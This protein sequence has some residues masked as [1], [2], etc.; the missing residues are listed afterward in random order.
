MKQPSLSAA[1][2]ISQKQRHSALQA[3]MNILQKWG[4]STEEMKKLLGIENDRELLELQQSSGIRNISAD[5]LERLSYLL[6]IHAAL[7]TSFTESDS[8]YGWVRKPNSDP[9][10]GGRSAMD[11]MTQGRVND[12]YEVMR[13]LM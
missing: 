13:R 9:F 12:L 10:F 4:C 8:I 2:D 1:V 6:N 11:V 5:T 3:V 7:R